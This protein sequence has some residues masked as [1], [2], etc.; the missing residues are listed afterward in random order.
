MGITDRVFISIGSN[1]GDR[2][3]NCRKAVELLGA[4]SAKVSLVKTSSFYETQPWGVSVQGT[5][6][7]LAVEVSTLLTPKEL[8]VFL[9][10]IETRLGRVA[11]M[12]WGPRV[13]DLDIIYFGVET[14]KEDGLT[15]PHP[16]ARERGFVLAPL[17]EI[18][19]GAE[20]PIL[21]K[22]VAE[23]LGL[24]KESGVIRKLDTGV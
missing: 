9:K 21:K 15:I 4:D 1:I 13:I 18:A 3:V 22:T 12:R 20:D 5:F 19:P 16:R 11:K 10:D 24:L 2:V 23:L 7:N 6:I 8:L 17:A 14:L